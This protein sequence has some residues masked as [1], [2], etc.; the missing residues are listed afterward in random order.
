[1]PAPVGMTTRQYRY[2]VVSISARRGGTGGARRVTDGTAAASS[3]DVDADRAV[4]DAPAAV[5]L[6]DEAD[7]VGSPTVPVPVERIDLVRLVV[8]I[9][10]VVPL[11]VHAPFDAAV[12]VPVD[13]V[14]LDVLAADA[15]AQGLVAVQ[16][17]TVARPHD[18]QGPRAG[19]DE[20][21]GRGRRSRDQY[22]EQ[23][24]QQHGS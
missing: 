21:R 8:G 10:V 12:D 5:V 23:Q 9:V 18:L 11:V 13:L 4:R 17:R 16:C 19:A 24:A 6:G 22:E 14:V 20:V 15:G 3:F 7:R 1:M 2:R